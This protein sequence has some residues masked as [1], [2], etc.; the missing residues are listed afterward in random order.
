MKPKTNTVHKHLTVDKLSFKANPL[1]LKNWKN[2]QFLRW[3]HESH[4]DR[5]KDIAW[6][7][8]ELMTC[9]APEWTSV[10]QDQVDR[11]KTLDELMHVL[12][13]AVTHNFPLVAVRM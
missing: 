9:L 1:E 5:I 7:R 3:L 8:T 12:T 11:A 4:Q 2:H 6:L 10:I 13:V